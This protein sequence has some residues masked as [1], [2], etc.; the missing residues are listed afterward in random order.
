MDTCNT[1]GHQ[2]TPPQ[3]LG[4]CNPENR[5][6]PKPHTFPI[7]KCTNCPYEHNLHTSD[8]CLKCGQPN[9]LM[10][11]K[12]AAQVVAAPV[13]PVIMVQ[14][15]V[16]APVK[17]VAQ[18]Q[19]PAPNVSSTLPKK[20]PSST[21]VNVRRA[22]NSGV[23]K[24]NNEG[25]INLKRKTERKVCSKCKLRSSVIEELC[26]QCFDSKPPENKA[27]RKLCSKCTSRPIAT[28][29][30]CQQCFDSK[31][32]ENKAVRK[33]CSKCRS[34]PI[35]TE[36]LCQQCFD[37]KPPENKGMQNSAK[38]PGPHKIVT[39]HVKSKR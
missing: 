29:E 34:R 17:P 4:E 15:P 26:Q 30:L 18:E 7:W 27:V 5:V 39:T 22:E 38:K 14:F 13:E 32:P 16:T 11:S 6:V 9:P 25:Q 21:G 20:R 23:A 8:K 31:P 28:E 3:V 1:C 33:L 24:S 2:N 35:A 36:E 37:S 10:Q 12:L 19:A